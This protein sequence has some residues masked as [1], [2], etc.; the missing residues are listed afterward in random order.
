VEVIGIYCVNY[1]ATFKHSVQSI[2]RVS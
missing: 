1:I 2:C